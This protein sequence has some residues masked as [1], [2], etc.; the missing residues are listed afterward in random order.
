MAG[1]ET[2]SDEVRTTSLALLS[3]KYNSKMLTFEEGKRSLRPCATHAIDMIM[4]HVPSIKR[5]LLYFPHSAEAARGGDID[6]DGVG[7]NE[8]GAGSGGEWMTST[9]SSVYSDAGTVC[10]TTL[11]LLAV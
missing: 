4:L 3:G 7:G 1:T 8:T 10:C 5:I 11:L 9:S 6:L 2:V